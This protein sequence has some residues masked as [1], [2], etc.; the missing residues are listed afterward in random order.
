[1]IKINPIIIRKSRNWSQKKLAEYIGVNQST[2]SRWE[3][4]IPLRGPALKILQSLLEDIPR[5][6]VSEAQGG[7]ERAEKGKGESDV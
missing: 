4:G 2:V 6:P 5:P 7:D 3:N 1:M